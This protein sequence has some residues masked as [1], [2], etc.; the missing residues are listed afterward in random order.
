LRF[1]SQLTIRVP[2]AVAA[3]V[4]LAGCYTVLKHP[5]TDLTAQEGHDGNYRYSDCASCHS[6]GFSQPLVPDPYGYTSSWYFDYYG[7][8]WWLPDCGYGYGAA[9][10]GGRWSGGRGA[11]SRSGVAAGD[12]E[13]HVGGRGGIRPGGVPSRVPVYTPAPGSGGSAAPSVGPQTQGSSGSGNQSPAPT[14]Q[15]PG[16]TMKQ[17]KESS[18]QGSAKPPSP[19]PARNQ[20]DQG[21]NKDNKPKPKDDQSKSKDDNSR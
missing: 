3:A 11:G 10:P 18:N 20:N 17:G 15:Q 14:G 9:A 6:E 1:S 13:R 5:S 21:K 19:P 4:F 2:L 8:P 7:C 16:R 12:D